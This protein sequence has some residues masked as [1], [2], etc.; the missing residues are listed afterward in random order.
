M[1]ACGDG[2]G[3]HG[4][5]VEVV[6]EESVGRDSQQNRLQRGLSDYTDHIIV[7]NLTPQGVR[8]NGQVSRRTGGLHHE[9][10]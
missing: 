4:V 7:R 6:G 1:G 2:D 9:S 8:L 10:V 3:D 5:V